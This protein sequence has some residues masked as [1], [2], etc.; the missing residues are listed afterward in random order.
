MWVT[1]VLQSSFLV[2]LKHSPPNVLLTSKC[3]NYFPI[4]HATSASK[5]AYLLKSLCQHLTLLFSRN[6]CTDIFF[7][8]S[9]RWKSLKIIISMKISMSCRWK[10]RL[11]YV[12]SVKSLRL[13]KVTPAVKKYVSFN[14][15]VALIEIKVSRF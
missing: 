2:M 1:S 10:I 12:P 11:G 6:S 15:R 9:C 7:I 13:L 4:W 3:P 5:Q 14:W 8:M